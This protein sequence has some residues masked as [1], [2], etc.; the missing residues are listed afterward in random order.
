M[1]L[2]YCCINRLATANALVASRSNELAGTQSELSAA[3]I[4]NT[5]M[6]QQLAALAQAAAAAE[7]SAREQNEVTAAAAINA[8]KTEHAAEMQRRIDLLKM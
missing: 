8:L 1:L 4:R 3:N 5:T 6:Q 2:Q 7:K